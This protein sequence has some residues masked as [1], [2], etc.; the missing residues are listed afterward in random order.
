M[1]KK[2]EKIESREK[3]KNNK[4]TMRCLRNLWIS[5]D[6]EKVFL[7]RGK[8]R[9]PS[10]KEE[11]REEEDGDVEVLDSNTRGSGRRLENTRGEKHG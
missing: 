1:E 6:E 11:E 10:R 3:E 5:A 8:S 7:K 2:V 4:L 9:L